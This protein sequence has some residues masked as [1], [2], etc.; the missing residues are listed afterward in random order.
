MILKIGVNVMMNYLSRIAL[1]MVLVSG[2]TAASADNVTIK[3][4]DGSLAI[5]GE[6]ISDDGLNYLLKTPF[7]T[8]QIAK[9]AATCEGCGPTLMAM[10]D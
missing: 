7:G 4:A 2:A 8:M 6:L 9:T 3:M 10:A 5:A 1:A